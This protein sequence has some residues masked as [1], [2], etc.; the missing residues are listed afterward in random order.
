MKKQII[1]AVL[2]CGGAFGTVQLRKE[3][4][5]DVYNRRYRHIC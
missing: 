5:Y 1:V 3:Q 4:S 2:V